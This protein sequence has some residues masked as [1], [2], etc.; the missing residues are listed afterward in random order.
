VVESSKAASDVY[1]PVAGK[2]IEVNTKL[3]STP[4]LI[5]SDCYKDGW[6]CKIEIS[7][8]GSLDDLMDSKKYEEYLKEL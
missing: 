6:L 2:V 8:S 1:S 4:E 5:N 7:D 3:G